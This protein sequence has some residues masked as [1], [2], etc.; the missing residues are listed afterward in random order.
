[1]SNQAEERWP[2]AD[3]KQ[4]VAEMLNDPASPHWVKCHEVIRGLVNKQ[5]G[6]FTGDIKEDITEDVLLLVMEHI[7]DFQFKC[8]L[9]TW[10]GS[11]VR[12]QVASEARKRKRDEKIMPHPYLEDAQIGSEN[13]KDTWAS[14]PSTED[15]CIRQEQW[16]EIIS[17]MNEYVEKHANKDRNREIL[18]L[19][20]FEDQSNELTAI[21]LGVSAPVVGYIVRSAQRFI[22]E[23]L[24]YHLLP[25]KPAH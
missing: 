10:L 19:V 1:M 12:N 20:M 11:I 24:G 4:V 15:I 18:R 25:H 13:E 9:T 14:H 8:K 2:V 16:Q 6:N 22:R 17:A 23:K 21:R 3:E 7:A 5:A